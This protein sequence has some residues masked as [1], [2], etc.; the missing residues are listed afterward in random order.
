VPEGYI[1]PGIY[2][3]ANVDYGRVLLEFGAVTG[4]LVVAWVLT[5]AKGERANESK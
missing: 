4:L 1:S 2:A 5:H 3:W